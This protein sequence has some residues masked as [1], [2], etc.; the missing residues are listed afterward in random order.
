MPDFPRLR[1]DLAHTKINL[2]RA[3][4]LYEQTKA[5]REQAV[6]AGLNGTLGKNAEE[7]ERNLT[8]ALSSDTDYQQ[9]LHT[10][11]TAEAD[12]DLMAA[13]VETAEDARREHEWKIRARLA[14]A[15]IGRVQTDRDDPSGD[16]AFD[17]AI[18]DQVDDESDHM[19][20]GDI[21]SDYYANAPRPQPT[22]YN[23][24]TGEEEIP[25]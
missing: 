16:G 7:R 12:A 14:D 17:D 10:L 19:S 1:T 2:R 11:R 18:D 4:D 23:H 24:V 20:R 25:F 6:I 8:I 15:L 9:A 22:F 13:R 3:R 21:D 5:Q